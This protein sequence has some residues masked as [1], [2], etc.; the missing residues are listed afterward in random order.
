[1]TPRASVWIPSYN[2]A[3]YLPAAIESV[4][5]QTLTDLELVIADDGSSDG[6]LEIAERY[7]AAHPD[8][9]TVLTHPGHANRGCAATG[10]LARS[11]LTGRFMLGLASDDMLYPD[12]LERQVT[13]LERNPDVGLVYGYAH[14]VDDGGRR[15]PGVRTFGVDLTR[16]GRF[17]ERLVQGNQVPAITV[18]LRREC[19]LDAGEEDAT[20]VY[21][22][23]ELWVRAAA[24]W[25]VRFNPRPLAMY[26][27]HGRN[28]GI[29]IARATNL[30]RSREVT[31]VLRDRA[32][33]VGGR[34]ADPRVRAALDLQ[35][36]FQSFA[37]GDGPS[38]VASLRSAFERDPS[39]ARDPRWLGDWLRER[40][41]D[42]LLPADR[43]DFGSWATAT[44]AAA[45]APRAARRFQCEAAA[46][47][48]EARAIRLALDGRPTAA[49]SAAVTAIGRSPRR[50]GDRRLLT[51]IA[52]SF[53]GGA[54]ANG[55]RVAKRRLLGHR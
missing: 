30:E 6:S 49:R 39:L 17:V 37:A 32:E 28:T 48:H 52:D 31:A 51:L 24:H 2:H 34:L 1:V 42:S 36:A 14:L 7:G 3:S 41:L 13:I 4:L 21:S 20:L 50:L 11:R 15:V 54:P 8:R 40:L 27:V 5:G 55:L 25:D 26:R 29:N 23:W 46:A 53:V 16:G 43:D 22:D 12:A 9:I 18:M 35:L 44:I 45:V 38:A 47:E 33:R 10:N 19:L